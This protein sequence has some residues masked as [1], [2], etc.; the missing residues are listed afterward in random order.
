ME[1]DVIV[2]LN[3]TILDVNLN[4]T[5]ESSDKV[6][7]Y[8]YLCGENKE[9]VGRSK[10]R[11][12][13]AYSFDLSELGGGILYVKAFL[14]HDDV[15]FAKESE[16]IEYIS[17]EDTKRFNEFCMIKEGYEELAN[18]DPYYLYQMNGPHSAFCLLDG[19]F[20]DE[21]IGLFCDKYDFDSVAFK[22]KSILIKRK[23]INFNQSE[24]LFSG[25][26]RI[27]E[28]LIVG[29]RVSDEAKRIS[30]NQLGTFTYCK[31]VN[32]G[33]EIGTD[34]FGIGKIYYYHDENCF[35]CGN[36]YHMLLLLL[37]G[38]G[39]KME[40]NE[41]VVNA[42]LCKMNQ[43]FAQR[44]CRECEVAGIFILPVG[45]KILVGQRIEFIDASITQT[46]HLDRNITNDEYLELLKK[47]K[48]EILANTKA[49]LTS[50]QYDE[51]LLELTG[52]L[53]SRVSYSAVTNFDVRKKLFVSTIKD[54]KNNSNQMDIE[55][56]TKINSVYHFPWDNR[57][58]T[59]KINDSDYMQNKFDSCILLGGYYSPLEYFLSN[60]NV[61]IESVEGQERTLCLNSFY[62]EICCRPYF[63]R[64]LLIK[65]ED[66]EE[67]D[68]EHLL[69]ILVNRKDVLSLKTYAALK[70]VMKREL[71]QLPGKS[72]V[73]KYE[74]EYLFYRNSFHCFFCGI[75]GNCDTWSVLQSKNLYALCR[76]MYDKKKDIK[77]EL[78]IITELNPIL[79]CIPYEAEGDNL[80]K[81]KL[82]QEL[83]YSDERFRNASL[84]LE[85]TMDEWE[86]AYREMQERTV[87]IAEPD[88]DLQELNEKYEEWEKGWEKRFETLLHAIIQYDNGIFRNQF[89]IDVFVCFCLERNKTDLFYKTL[90]N[91]LL[92]I[93]L[94]L[95]IIDDD[96]NQLFVP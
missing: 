85:N 28:N 83:H 79:G 45:K 70:Q 96:Y 92:S 13:S 46:F 32:A 26:G 15:K 39:K 61:L 17:L 87:Y 73:E 16:E 24:I 93:F 94:Q 71:Q 2:T 67:Y 48:E 21:K 47:G 11:N 49:A 31:K 81:Q 80:S 95:R 76:K 34:Y 5:L 68:L 9:I 38:I 20:V 44:F 7:Y 43:P 74:A 29:N 42:L 60:Y 23:D 19:E 69:Q 51:I 63:T 62:G 25:I 27:G 12:D 18:I 53:D 75:L 52:G 35:A 56:A 58:K 50:D 36:S 33:L 90:Y 64:N 14:L 72:Y 40:I 37:K 65:F 84:K 8:L 89:G 55:V 88:Q 59:I 1:Y 30:D 66:V 3:G 77:M 82:S 91:K 41:E 22:E 4:I 86:E 10:W 78:D 6:Y 57:S 54:Q